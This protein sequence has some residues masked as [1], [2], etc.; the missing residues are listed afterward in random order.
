MRATTPENVPGLLDALAQELTENHYD[1]KHVIRLILNSRTYQLSAKSNATNTADD[2]YFSRFL[3]RPMPA[4]VLLDMINQATGVREP[5]TPWAERSRA[6]Q[7]AFPVGNYFLDAFGQSHR[8]FLADIDPKLEPNLVQTLHMINASYINDKVRGG[9]TVA[10]ALK[11]ARDNDEALDRLFI[12]TLGRT[13]TTTERA[14]AITAFTE[15]K[16]PRDASQDVLWALLTS[17]EFYFN[18]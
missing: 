12:R 8:E 6:I 9:T 4:Q 17:R 3:P 1:I 18:H 10:T 16:D 5:F 15:N 11:G 7:T 13:P 2:R 14:K